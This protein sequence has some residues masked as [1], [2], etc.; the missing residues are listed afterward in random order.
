MPCPAGESCVAGQC[1]GAIGDA[2]TN[3]LALGISIREIAV[4][5]AGKIPIM[6]DGNPVAEANRP[7]DI[8]QGKS[9][10]VRVF[11]DLESGWTNR[12]VSARLLLVNAEL[13]P[14]YFSKRTV[15]QA[16]TDSSF[17]TTFNFDVKPEDITATT[18]YTVEIVECDGTPA[19]SA[20]TPRFPT[21]DSQE[22]LT[23]QTGLLKV[24]FIPLNANG[25]TAASDTARLENYSTFLQR[26]YPSTNV[27]Y[28]LGG[29]LNVN[30]T[31]S[32]NGSGWS[33]A[34][35]QLAGLHEDDNAANDVY[36]YGLFQPTDNIGQYCGGGCVAGIGFVTGTQS[37][38]RHQRVSLGLSY[39]NDSSSETLAHEL[40]HNHGR[41]HSP[42]GGAGSP[43]N[44]Y[45]HA[46]ARIGWWGYEAPETL[47]NPA[48]DTDIM[49]YCNNQWVSDYVY[50]F[51]T[52][53][54]ALLNGAPREIP[55]PGGTQHFLF[56][57]TDIT[58]PRWGIERKAPRYPSGDPEQAQILDANGNLVTTVTVYRTPTDHLSGA[59]ILVPYPEEGWHAV[60]ITGEVPLSFG[61]ASMSRP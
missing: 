20:G 40:G 49:G 45:P 23:R 33:E 55:P 15:S 58:G 56:L 19:G 12:V 60:Q 22:L 35:D 5:Q 59:L 53:R 8:V 26:M 30:Q 3:T 34:L 43:D 32:A 7:A 42:C 31:V 38:A 28:T 27:E 36:Y 47:H 9:A 46:G 18:R 14:S 29:A 39:A 4:Y 54:I 25:R 16:S 13:T 2:C 6:Q 24:R 48:N 44:N 10:R 41:T 37:Y 11:V 57:L 21:S 61:S 17:A 50:R 1:S 51:F 52:D